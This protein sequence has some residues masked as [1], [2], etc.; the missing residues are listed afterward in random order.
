MYNNIK[1]NV[2]L[3]DLQDYCNN[4]SVLIVGNS[5][6][7]IENKFGQKIDSYDIVVRLNHGHIVNNLKDR[8]G[9]KYNIWGHGFLNK[10][11][12]LFEYVKIKNIIDYHIETSVRKLYAPLNDNKCFIVN[13]EWYKS[14]YEKDTG[15]EMST[16]LNVIFLFTRCIKNI[17]SLSI[18]G[19]DFLRTANPLLKS[20]SARY[21]NSDMEEKYIKNELKELSKYIPFNEKYKY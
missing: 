8:M 3:L 14:Q 9:K 2:T 16:G 19:F 7:I 10:K 17:K 11:A 13:G 4:K 15:V 1:K 20:F 5:K 21:H 6:E 12:Q 18:V